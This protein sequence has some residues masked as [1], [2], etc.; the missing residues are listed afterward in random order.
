LARTTPGPI[1]RYLQILEVTAAAHDGLGLT[2]IT[3]LTGLPKPTVHR[4][5]NALV[6]AQ[7]LTSDDAWHKTFRVGPRIWRMLLL[8]Q[9]RDFVSA[10]AQIIVDDLANRFH[11]TAYVVRLDGRRVRSIARNAPDQGHRLHVLPGEHLPP[12]AAASAKAILAY[13]DEMLIAE[14]LQ[15]PLE[16]MTVHTK[17]SPDA[18]RAELV[19]VRAQGYAVCDREIDENICAFATPVFLPSADVLYSVGI[20]GPVSRLMK[21]PPEHWIGPMKQAAARFAT[22]LAAPSAQKG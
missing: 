22:M 13:Q 12:H 2:E 4:L 19:Q 17:T 10:I 7:A 20:T 16:A 15:E 3:T 5:V 21:H 14:M 9:N 18:V 11:E 6:D 8:G 1:E